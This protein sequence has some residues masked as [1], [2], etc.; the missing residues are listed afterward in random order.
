[1]AGET[2]PSPRNHGRRNFLIGAG[3]VTAA[4]IGGVVYRGVRRG[5]FS[6]SEGPA[7][8]LWETWNADA[9]AGTPLALVAAGALAAS[10]HNTQPWIFQVQPDRI[11][12]YADRSRNLGA[13]DPFLRE[14]YLGLGCALENM[15]LAGPANGFAVAPSPQTGSLNPGYDA[16]QPALVATLYLSPSEREPG[17]LYHAI[18]KRHTNRGPYDRERGLDQADLAALPEFANGVRQRIFLYTEGEDRER[19]DE[20]VVRATET[21]IADEAMAHDSERWFR[22]TA[23]QA[24]RHRDGIT[25]EAN[26]MHPA[27]LAIAKMMPAVS[28]EEAHKIWLRSTKDTHLATAPVTG[29]LAVRSLYDIPQTLDAGRLWQRVH[30][31]AASKGIAM[32]PLNQPLE[33]AD[34]E[35][36][37]RR[38]PDTGRTL[39][40]LTGD[41][42]WK[43]TFAFRA[44]YPKRAAL[45]SPRRALRDVAVGGA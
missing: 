22:M 40:H 6:T 10:P 5:A 1:M 41:P 14:M 42:A 37:L 44:G 19:F 21:I 31:W 30:L 18:S 16:D 33:V 2:R 13:F 3:A 25:L 28:G 4:V 36:Y 43:P 12:L 23:A 27:M 38:E 35:L 15:I 45:P 11:D 20:T 7:Y 24:R 8:E 29:F 17:T 32:H 26:G 34:R 39:E 9:R